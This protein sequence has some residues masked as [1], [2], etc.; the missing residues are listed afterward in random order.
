M[1]PEAESLAIGALL[2]KA[3]TCCQDLLHQLHQGCQTCQ[4]FP[5]GQ[6][7]QV[8][9]GGQEYHFSLAARAGQSHRKGCDY[10]SGSGLV[11]VGL[12]ALVG[13]AG[14]GR[15]RHRICLAVL[16]HPLD[17]ELQ[18]VSRLAQAQ[19]LVAP[20]RAESVGQRLAATSRPKLVFWTGALTSL[21]YFR[22]V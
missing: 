6:L 15:H 7:H 10:L 5:M 14:L 11:L 21:S 13:L 18:Q 16:G 20:Q 4:D 9:L 2:P 3:A 8:H 19:A 12:L 17:L 22:F 1:Q